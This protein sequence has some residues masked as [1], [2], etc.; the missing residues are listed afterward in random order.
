MN[1]IWRVCIH[2]YIYIYKYIY[3]YVCIYRV[4]EVSNQFLFR[5]QLSCN[6][7]TKPNNINNNYKQKNIKRQRN[8]TYMDIKLKIA[9]ATPRVAQTYNHVSFRG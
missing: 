7:K 6:T 5:L 3:L 4:D 1:I 8:G 9:S 2:T